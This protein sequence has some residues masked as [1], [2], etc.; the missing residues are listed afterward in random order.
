MEEVQ[1]HELRKG[2]EANIGYMKPYFNLKKKERKKKGELTQYQD[3][4]GQEP[5][6]TIK[7][8]KSCFN[9]NGCLVSATGQNDEAMFHF[10]ASNL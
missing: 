6:G 3:C 5:H 1:G 9:P 8:I 10:S 7:K 4:T 2:F